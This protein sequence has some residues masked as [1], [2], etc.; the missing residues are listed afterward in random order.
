MTAAARRADPER[1]REWLS[2]QRVF[3]S[4]AMADTSPERRAV[5]A[6]IEDEGA[7]PVWFEEFGRDAD[8]E[9][10][11]L[12]EV[13]S[14]TIHVAILNEI[15]GRPNPP[16]GDSA[17]EMEYMRARDGGKRVHVLVAENVAAREGALTR[18]IERIRFFITTSPYADADDAARR[19]RRRLHELASE[20]LSPWVKLGDLVFRADEIFDSET[21]I[22]IRARVSD[23]ISHQLEMLRGDR[24][25]RNRLRFVNRGRVRDGEFS[26]LGRVTR[27][28][29][30]DEL[31]IELTSV[32]S[33]DVDPFRSGAQGIDADDLVEHGV[34]A[35]LFGE[36]LPQ[37]LGML[38]FMADSGINAE[39]L[40]Q[41]FDL[42]NEATLYAN[43]TPGRRHVEGEWRRR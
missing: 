16:D 33:P 26:A 37:Q 13:D 32:T 15:Y 24:Y 22:T 20:A 36:P 43:V 28:S 17:T 9:E 14:S 19:V 23:E 7:T 8:A 35:L 30:A 3:I 5:A 31:T 21:T 40:R 29:G 12:T 27:A 34:R 6:A 10:A 41:A 4:S 18:F 1:I 25:T 39:D 11:Y 38:E 2:E 42:P